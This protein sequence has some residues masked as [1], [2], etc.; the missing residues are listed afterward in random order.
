MDSMLAKMKQ[1]IQPKTWLAAMVA[2]FGVSRAELTQLILISELS[3][4]E[5]DQMCTRLGKSWYMNGQLFDV[6]RMSRELRLSDAFKE[7]DSLYERAFSSLSANKFLTFIAYCLLDDHESIEHLTSVKIIRV[8]GDN[9]KVA[10]SLQSSLRNINAKDLHKYSSATMYKSTRYVTKT[11]IAE[12][13]TRSK[14]RLFTV[15]FRK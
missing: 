12:L 13:F 2:Y 11:E 5:F 15:C 1:Y 4:S 9:L 7:V 10:S 8:D 14:R 3:A 6:H